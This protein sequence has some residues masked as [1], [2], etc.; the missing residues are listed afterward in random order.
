MER[1]FGIL[2]PGDF[3]HVR[4]EADHHAF[5]HVRHIVDEAVAPHAGGP[6]NQPLEA[7]LFALQH[8]VDV[9]LVQGEQV[10]PE[11]FADRL[12]DQSI[13]MDAEPLRVGGVRESTAQ[14][15]IPVRQ[16]RRHPVDQPPQIIFRAPRSQ[17]THGVP[18]A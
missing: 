17:F 6:R 1:G 9:G 11:N 7:L 4:D 16:H 18:A 13:Q 3:G 5:H 8:G 15:P 12:A 2:E 10:S 14:I